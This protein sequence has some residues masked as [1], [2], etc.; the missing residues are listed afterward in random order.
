VAQAEVP[1]TDPTSGA[2]GTDCQAATMG[3]GEQF[4][5]PDAVV[6]ALAC[7]LEA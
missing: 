2:R 1:F 6:T 3:T 4:A 7:V 5:S